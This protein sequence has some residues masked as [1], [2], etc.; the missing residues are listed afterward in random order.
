[1]S[2]G[3]GFLSNL[4]SGLPFVSSHS[5]DEGSAPSIH[6]TMATSA[7]TMQHMF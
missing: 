6:N 2:N 5:D 4:I 1:M 3:N 7:A